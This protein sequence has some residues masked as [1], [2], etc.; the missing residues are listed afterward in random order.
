MRSNPRRSGRGI[1]LSTALAAFA[2]LVGLGDAQAQFRAPRGTQAAPWLVYYA[3]SE[4]PEAFRAFDLLVLDSQFH[5]P[6]DVL[7]DRGKVLLGYISLGEVEQHRPWFEA[8][9]AEGILLQENRFWPG[10]FFV[11]LRDKR[12]VERVIEELVPAVLHA[13]FDGLFFDTLDNP[14]YLEE[15]DPQAYAGM[16]EAAARLV[17]AIRLNYPTVP[18][19]MNR[20]YGL[21]PEVE[22]AIDMVL[23]ESV[24]ADYDFETESY[25]HV[26]TALYREQVALLKAAQARRPALRVMTLDYWNP[27]DRA[28]IEE[29]YRVQR[30][31]GFEPYVAT[32]NLDVIVPPPSGGE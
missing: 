9:R 7:R 13:G 3:D 6:L 29:I 10:S 14:L 1:F 22:T 12:W 30:S 8:V 5:P 20:A 32:I 17:R 28:G 16:T 4:P 15:T 21:L 2:A 25:R 26:E 19:M 31:N 24:Y 11:D 23:G 18:I 27:E